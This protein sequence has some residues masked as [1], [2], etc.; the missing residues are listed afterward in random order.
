MFYML[1]WDAPILMKILQLLHRLLFNSNFS[2]KL[3]WFNPHPWKS[4]KASTS[5]STASL[6][7]C[8]GGS[9]LCQIVWVSCDDR[10]IV[11]PFLGGTWSRK[12]AM[13]FVNLFM[14]LSLYGGC[15]SKKDGR[16]INAWSIFTNFYKSSPGHKTMWYIHLWV[17]S[18]SYV[19]TLL[20]IK[21][22]I[23]RQS[24]VTWGSI[25]KF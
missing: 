25:Y 13:I 24:F 4:G 7:W 10:M 19:S 6:W 3:S 18:F 8:Y 21:K 23:E 14:H 17:W 5:P 22:R 16:S 20:H 11:Y 15:S 1:S 9:S 12:V 2:W